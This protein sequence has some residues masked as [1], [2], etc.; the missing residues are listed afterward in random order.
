KCDLSDHVLCS[1]HRQSKSNKVYENSLYVLNFF[2][3]FWV[4]VMICIGLNVPL[5]LDGITQRKGI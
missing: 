4:G 5:L 2:P 3:P 1:V